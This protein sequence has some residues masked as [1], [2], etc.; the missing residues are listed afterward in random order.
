MVEPSAR[1]L[2]TRKITYPWQRFWCVRGGT[3]DLSDY[4]F[5][6]DPESE[7]WT[8]GRPKPLTLEEV[9]NHRALILLGE[10]GMGKSTTLEQEVARLTQGTTQAV[11]AIKVD[12]RA[13]S[14]EE[15]LYRRVF[16]SA[17]FQGW[18]R[19]TSQLVLYLD[20]LD[21][22]LLRIDSIA[23]LLADELPRHPTE[24]LS[25]RIACRTAVWPVQI[26]EPALKD[27]WGEAA[28]GAF[29]LAPLRRTDV[30]SA[31]SLHGVDSADF[32]RAVFETDVVPLAIKPLTLNMLLDIYKR[33]ARLPDSNGELYRR[34]CLVL[35]DDLNPSRRDSR[36]LGS[37]TAFQRL[38]VA[39]RIAATTMLANCFA[40]WA[41]AESGDIPPEDVRVSALTGES[42]Q[43]D[44]STFDVLDAHIREVLDTG[45]FSARG[46]ERM[47][48]AHQGYAEFLT[49]EYLVEK[50]VPP[51]TVLKL[52]RH[53][54]GGLIPQ[55]SVVA[56]WVAS[57]SPTIRHELIESE[58]LVLLRGDLSRWREEDRA[59]LAAAYLKAL[60]DKRTTD[61]QLNVANFYLRLE[62][63]GL[64]A[65]L[66]GYIIDLDKAIMSRRAAIMIA[67]ACALITLES[68]LLAL[69]MNVAEDTSLRAR[70]VAA[71]RTCGRESII[72]LLMPFAKGTAG[73]DPQ[74][75][76]RGHSLEL[77]WPKY[78][79]AADLFA[80]IV[81]P[82]EGF[83]G[84]YVMFLYTLPE[85]LEVHDLP[86][87][88]SWA[89]SY[90]ASVDHIGVFAL[91][92]L[93]D[94]ILVRAWSQIGN[95]AILKGLVAYIRECVAR[96][97]DLFRGADQR[98]RDQFLVALKS[99]AE[100][101]RSFLRAL[102]SERLERI[103]VYPFRRDSFIQVE[104]LE[105]MLRAAPGGEAVDVA[106]DEETLCNLVENAYVQGDDRQFEQLQRAAERWP[107]LY[108]RYR[109]L[110]EG[111]P[112]DSPEAQAAKE[113]HRMM[114]TFRQPKPLLSPPPAD[115]VADALAQFEAGNWRAF[116][117]LNLHL[118][119]TPTSQHFGSDLQ[120]DITT[121]PGWRDADIATRER[122]VKAAER[123]LQIGKTSVL[124]WIGTNRCNQ[125]D[126][127]AF[128]ALLL[129]LKHQP[130]V[131][132]RLATEVWR[133][134]APAIAALPRSGDDKLMDEQAVVREA[135][136]KAPAEFVAAIRKTIRCERRDAAATASQPN[137]GVRFWH[138]QGLKFC[139][140][141]PA[142]CEAVFSELRDTRNTEGEFAVLA[143]IL[144]SEGYEP[145]RNYV[146]GRLQNGAFQGDG[147]AVVAINI[148]L[149][150]FIPESWSVVWPLLRNND[151][152]ARRVFLSRGQQYT[153][154]GDA[155]VRLP[156]RELAE[157]HVR[158][159]RLFP[160]SND[161]VHL[162]GK[163][164][165]VGPLER[166]AHLRDNLLGQLVGRGTPEAVLALRWTIGQLPE[167]QWLPF[168][169]REAEQL[170]RIRTWAPLSVAEVRRL[171]KN[172][173]AQLVQVPGDLA[174]VIVESL[175]RYEDELHG[176]QAPVRGL[177]DR[178]G[179]GTA[180]RPVEEDALSDHVK[181]FLQRDLAPSEIVV[182]REV[183]ISRVPG[184]PVGTRT[185]IR[186]Q[187]IRRGEGNNVLD[188]ITAVI[189]T[190]GCWNSALFSSLKDQ[191]HDDYM[192]RLGAPV[193]IYLVGWFDKAKWDPVDS[194]RSRTPNLSADEAQRR[195]NSQAA[196]LPAES[197]VRAVVLDCHLP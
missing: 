56:A 161:P 149:A 47:G 8:L 168:R 11:T 97:G 100:P 89:R 60:E 33:E 45:L 189:E 54:D 160:R 15:L 103:Q 58:P 81:R 184:A 101:R 74:D 147:T 51:A 155:L 157:L 13:F 191:L 107:L 70:A 126:L 65:L 19:G 76:L 188:T 176:E 31:A 104:D 187:A 130:E 53:P 80:S 98:K 159:E 7:F 91:N 2:T 24:R 40:I 148:L 139:W 195:F 84:S 181:L 197:D 21:E 115:R 30:K 105:W 12:L 69:V 174:E 140:R 93:A 72:P 171:T 158:M 145:A 124:S 173:R 41:G 1:D 122:I 179:S 14:S 132:S 134:W 28:V 137:Q 120:F 183:E 129:L 88:L 169:L 154:R 52:F 172:K 5:M 67:E 165:T 153:F 128:R 178:Q 4:G 64:A 110:F 143:E 57:L 170:M 150:H 3:I 135:L 136:E 83:T 27:I 59:A 108:S 146:V 50:Q 85:S 193:G 144:I 186:V 118:T 87:A 49:A 125:N 44:S 112:I 95:D 102:A 152:F 38:R 46:P 131:Y 99:Q 20:S 117:W 42:E 55:L 142:I 29:E 48:W 94:S 133:K 23:S 39:G 196:D 37:L 43:V 156:E 66:R 78:L 192:A 61:F 26:L 162:G 163:V 121:L 35:C 9:S 86:I 18:A 164:H 151:E 111:V 90:I 166:V 167:L 36:R 190:K 22:A 182:N 141:H 92:S 32:F 68:E 82:N 194:R 109:F 127:A 71:L 79:S 25:I 73:E 34:G 75:E 106:L 96:G 116:W 16:E 6:L 62:H 114:Q 177:W 17:E 180:F 175:R 123:Y 63:S 77:L 119:L 185:D 10:P 113:Q 138:L